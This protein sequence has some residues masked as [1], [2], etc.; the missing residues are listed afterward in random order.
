MSILPSRRT[1]PSELPQA[2]SRARAHTKLSL[3]EYVFS[4]LLCP[5]RL[6]YLVHSVPQGRACALA[7]HMVPFP[8]LIRI[9]A[10]QQATCKS[11]GPTESPGLLVGQTAGELCQP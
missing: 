5:V 7:T 8:W 10:G 1:R 2:K 11:Q 9:I 4:P 3:T 6:N